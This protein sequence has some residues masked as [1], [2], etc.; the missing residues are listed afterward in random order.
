MPEKPVSKAAVTG[1]VFAVLTLL[2]LVPFAE[3]VLFTP[4]ALVFG[5]LG[6]RATKSG[7][8]KGRMQA[9]IAVCVGWIILGGVVLIGIAASLA[10]R[11]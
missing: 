2:F 3:G 4:L 8:Y 5:Y 9:M 7:E 11:R 6:L 1:L 10:S